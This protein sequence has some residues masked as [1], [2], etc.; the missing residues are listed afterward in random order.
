[1]DISKNAQTI[2]EMLEN[3]GFEA[4]AVGGCVRDF[5]MKRP[6]SDIDITTS[7]MPQSVENVFDDNNVRYIETGLKHGTITAL[8]GGESFEVTT[9]RIDGDYKDNRHPEKVEFVT[10]IKGDLAR[11]DFTINAMAY[12]HKGSVVDLFGGQQDIENKIIRAVGDADKRFKEDAL[13]IMR[14]IR[15]ASVLSFDIEEDTKKA[16]FDNKELLKNVSYER[17]YK[18]LSKLLMGDNVY[19]VLVEYKE[20]IGVIIPE[21]VP[22]FNVEQN[23]SWHIYDVWQHTAKAVES[24]PKDLALRYTMLLHDIGKAYMKTTDENGTDHFKG[25]Q[26]VS[27]QY[28]AP[29]LKRLKAPNCVYERAMAIIPIHDMHI[30]I[31]RGNVKKWLSKLG[32]EALRDLIAVKRADKL[33]QNP[34]KIGEE[35]DNLVITEQILNSIIEDGEPFSLKDLNINGKDLMAL[36]LEGRQIG[37]MLEHVLDKVV[38]NVLE[39]KKDVLISYIESIKNK[40]RE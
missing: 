31:K 27:A 30:G 4:Y 5:I 35:L 1:M 36:G 16:I 15:F 26:A 9:Y 22:I 18:E 2:I 7:A 14:A 21:L 29:A 6:C 12:N 34:A 32:E 38:D 40:N 28:A 3:S 24:A 17:I 39:N 13:R 19:T 11:R 33:A 10:D 23:T 20:I 25:H 8:L 37:E